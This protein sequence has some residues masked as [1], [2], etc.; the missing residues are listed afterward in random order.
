MVL[1]HAIDPQIHRIADQQLSALASA[2]PHAAS[3]RH[4]VNVQLE[5]TLTLIDDPIDPA[6]GDGA[7]TQSTISP[8]DAER[9][10]SANAIVRIAVISANDMISSLP[11]V[12]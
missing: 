2:T 7:S 8:P 5:P 12:A 6:T 3:P 1:H 11:N 4:D 9:P 10:N